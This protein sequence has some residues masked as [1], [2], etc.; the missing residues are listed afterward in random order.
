MAE[1]QK[2]LRREF[3]LGAATLSTLA[4]A[5]CA[6]TT[7]TPTVPAQP[8]YDPFY[9][10]MYGPLPNEKFPVPAVELK[11]LDPAYYRR[12]VDYPTTE[13]PGTLIVDTGNRYLYLV[14][15][16]GQ[17]IRYGCGIGRDGFSWSGRGNIQ[18][19]K[20]W[21]TWTPPA[22]MIGRQPELEK[23]RGGQPGGL[24]N[25]LGARA[26]Y[27]F[28]D[29]RDTI[30]RVHGSGEAWTMGKAVS[31]GCVRLLHH[32][33]IDLYDRVVPGAGIIVA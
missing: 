18:Y 22:E 28:K 29:G 4:L 16:G 24:D 2:M 1:A 31:S 14:G 9:V 12:V 21:P 23:W 27:I 30:Y 33:I 17:A 3:I 20:Q 32:D 25:P 6:T 7:P 5:G 26:L 8:Q 19:K 15:E 13:R 10:N 11:Y